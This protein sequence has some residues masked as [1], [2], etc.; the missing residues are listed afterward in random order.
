LSNLDLSESHFSR[1][2]WVLMNRA[3]EEGADEPAP[4]L[5]GGGGISRS[6][7]GETVSLPF[8]DASQSLDTERMPWV[9]LGPGASFK[10]LRFLP[11]NRGRVLLLRLDPGTVVPLHRHLGEVHGFNL[12]GHRKLLETGE[13]IGPG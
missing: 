9:P 6:P 13:V 11:N 1:H 2:H 7:K 5:P 10:R 12:A 3:D 4:T 8:P